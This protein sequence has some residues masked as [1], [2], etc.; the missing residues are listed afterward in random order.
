MNYRYYKDFK[1]QKWPSNSLKV[2]SNHAIRSAT[3]D[4]LLVFHGN[5]VSIL[6]HFQNI[7][8]YFPKFKDVTWHSE[9]AH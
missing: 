4:F 8:A 2:I 1:Q 3:Y 7:I 9:H 6:H 5:Y